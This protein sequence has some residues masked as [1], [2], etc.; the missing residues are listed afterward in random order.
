MILWFPIFFKCSNCLTRDVQASLYGLPSAGTYPALKSFGFTFPWSSIQKGGGEGG[1]EHYRFQD[2]ESE[3]PDSP[4]RSHT[5]F[6]QAKW[7]C[8]LWAVDEEP[9]GRAH[10]F[11]DLAF[12][13]ISHSGGISALFQGWISRLL[14]HIL[15]FNLFFPMF[16]KYC[17]IPKAFFF[18]CVQD[19]DLHASLPSLW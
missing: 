16:F 10:H 11:L 5:W 18:H 7:Q 14:S 17:R 4:V 2:Q 9:Q 19:G 13:L 3:F 8:H 15:K 6:G 1:W 12:H